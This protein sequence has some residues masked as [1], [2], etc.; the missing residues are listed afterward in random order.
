[1]D[2]WSDG[3]GGMDWRQTT[4]RDGVMRL[5]ST[6]RQSLDG[7]AFTLPRGAMDTLSALLRA[8]GGRLLL[9][10]SDQG[11]RDIAQIRSGLLEYRADQALD[12]NA[13]QVLRV[14]FEALARWHLAHGA[15]VQQTQRDDDGRI[16]HLALHDTPGGRL[17]ECLPEIIG[18]PHPDDHLQVLLALDALSAATP[19]QCFSIL[20]AQAWDP[21]TFRVLSRH[22]LQSA[23]VLS[24]TARMQWLEM[25][26]YCRTQHYPPCNADGG[27]DTL[28]ELF[29]GLARKLGDPSLSSTSSQASL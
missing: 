16:L 13:H 11:A 18:L 25:L 10:A 28:S 9:R 26:A 4:Q 8:S 27:E 20:H 17:Q 2:A 15:S 22:L 12:Q 3:N 21:R 23:A 1:L 7:A 6:Y 5:L 29:A 19:S 24:R 14:N